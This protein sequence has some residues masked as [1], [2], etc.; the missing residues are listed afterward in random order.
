VSGPAAELPTASPASRRHAGRRSLPPS[1]S[2]VAAAVAPLL[3]WHVKPPAAYTKNVGRPRVA[4][5]RVPTRYTCPMLL[6]RCDESY[7]DSPRTSP[8]YV[9]AG[10]VSSYAQWWEFDRR[11]RRSMKALGIEALGCHAS[12]CA[13]G[14]KPYDTFSPTQRGEIQGQM[15]DAIRDSGIFGCVAVGELDGWRKRRQ[16]LTDYLGKDNKKFNE[17]HLL[18]HRQCVLLMFR[19]TEPATKEQIAF[20]FDQNTD[21]G[22][23]AREWYHQTMKSSS[24]PAEELTRMGPYSESDRMK[25]LGL[26][27]ADILAY[28]AFRHF[29]GKPSW[30]WD[31][32]IARKQVTAMVFDDSYWQVLEVEAAAAIQ[33][34]ASDKATDG[35]TASP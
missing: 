34:R 22:G 3:S 26:Q 2:L 23:R 14:A 28:A 21:T 29:S 20:V 24:L 30:Q 13:T 31:A 27:A 1:F 25:T 16:L 6:A 12:K 33:A 5:G 11:W 32:L 18:A 10:Y 19:I 15:I 4:R 17:P 9:V 7:A 35:S 8:I